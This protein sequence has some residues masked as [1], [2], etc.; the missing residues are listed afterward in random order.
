MMEN[1]RC[2]LL[3]EIVEQGCPVI[4]EGLTKTLLPQGLVFGLRAQRYYS[5]PCSATPATALSP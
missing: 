5:V 4:K 2:R 1:K 3:I